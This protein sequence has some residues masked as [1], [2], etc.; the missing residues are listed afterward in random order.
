MKNVNGNDY[1][2]VLLAKRAEVLQGLHRRED[3][4]V[5]QTN[6]QVE[7]VQ[8]AA[9]RDYAVHILELEGTLLR[10]IDA[11]LARIDDGEFGICLECEQPISP[12]RLNAVPWASYCLNCQ[13][14]HENLH[15]P[16]VDSGAHFP[17]LA[18]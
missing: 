10:Q 1:R 2:S 12:K 8:L 5:V 3:I 4:H 16:T 18:A 17:S 13:E 14:Y 15:G 6:E 7:T 11:S 9:Q